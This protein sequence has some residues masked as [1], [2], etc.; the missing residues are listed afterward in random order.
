MPRS[1][2]RESIQS[3]SSTT[4]SRQVNSR[5]DPLRVKLSAPPAVKALRDHLKANAYKTFPEKELKRIQN[6][7]GALQGIV[8]V[9]PIDHGWKLEVLGVGPPLKWSGHWAHGNAKRV[10]G[11]YLDMNAAKG[12]FSLLEERFLFL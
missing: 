4:V 2:S 5:Q 7:P 12:I 3:R 11:K 6:N 9:E 1:T 10:R 8:E